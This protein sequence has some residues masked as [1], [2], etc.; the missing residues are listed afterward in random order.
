[1]E[2]IR[3]AEGRSPFFRTVGKIR[4]GRI[5]VDGKRPVLSGQSLSCLITLPA[6]GLG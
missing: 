3:M 6:R 4:A 1:M 5:G 2:R